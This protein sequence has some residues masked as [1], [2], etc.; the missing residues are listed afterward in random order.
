MSDVVHNSNYV[1][2][3]GL[4]VNC[5]EEILAIESISIQRL[6]LRWL[7]V[8]FSLKE[9]GLRKCILPMTGPIQGCTY[10]LDPSLTI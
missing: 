1:V 2:V 7:V 8:E 10:V 3:T 4:L 9:I 6:R 5:T